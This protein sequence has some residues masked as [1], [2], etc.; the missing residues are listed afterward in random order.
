MT[1]VAHDCFLLKK[2]ILNDS[3]IIAFSSDLRF[4]KCWPMAS[5]Q[6]GEAAGLCV[7]CR[8]LQ[9]IIN[10]SKQRLG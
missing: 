10:Q 7:S 2:H 1:F 9:R 3:R 5:V 4:A 8:L 6:P